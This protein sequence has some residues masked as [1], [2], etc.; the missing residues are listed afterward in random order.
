MADGEERHQTTQTGRLRASPPI[1]PPWGRRLN[2]KI[3][4]N[5]RGRG[6]NAGPQKMVSD[7]LTHRAVQ[8]EDERKSGRES[9]V[10]AGQQAGGE[11]A[12]HAMR[13]ILVR[14]N[15]KRCWPKGTE[16]HAAYSAFTHGLQQRWSFVKRTIQASAF[17]SD[18][19][20]NPSEK[21]FLPAL[22]KSHIIIGDNVREL[23]TFPPRLGGVGSR[24]L[25]KLADEKP[26]LINLTSSLTEK[27]KTS[28]R[29]WVKTDPN[30]ILELKKTPF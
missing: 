25:R 10:C 12:I 18:R 3:P 23:L 29:K 13:E 8:A 28:R 14:K 9:K 5:E 11:A 16:P 22:L 30:A 21:P 24:P 6:S 17:S 27:I 20:K 1:L 4:G 19:W 7:A 2:G 26:K 15:V